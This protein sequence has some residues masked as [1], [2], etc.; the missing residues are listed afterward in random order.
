M[1]HRAKSN[2]PKD[3]PYVSKGGLKL[4]FALEHFNLSVQNQIAADFGSHQGGFVDCLLKHGAVRVYSI[5]TSYGT[6]AWSLRN[7]HRVVVLERTNA[8]HWISPEPLDIITI[9]V[10]WTRQQ[11]ILPSAIQAIHPKGVIL[12]LLKPQYEIL[13]K[14][15]HVLSQEEVN[16]VINSLYPW[17]L[18][19]FSSIKYV[20]SPYEGSGGNIEAWLCL[21]E[22][23]IS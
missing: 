14:S 19:R 2:R 9:D 6:L 1:A 12:S 15:Q 23:K 3:C 17:L 7:D 20:F 16:Q 21:T 18:E 10:A 5:D 4:Q 13:E 8:M 22:K 11:H